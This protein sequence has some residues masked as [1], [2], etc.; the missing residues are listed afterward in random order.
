MISKLLMVA[1]VACVVVV[2]YG[3]YAFITGSFPFRGD[4]GDGGIPLISAEQPPEN[5]VPV[6]IPPLEIEI[7]EAQIYFNG[8]VVTLEEMDEIIA[9]YQAVSEIWTL[10]DAFRADKQTFDNVRALLNERGVRVVEI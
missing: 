6:D 4:G 3:I 10:A 1:I 5:V 2:A 7:R 9:R 8:E